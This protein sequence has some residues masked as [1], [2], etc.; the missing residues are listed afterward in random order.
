[1]GVKTTKKSK[2]CNIKTEM[3]FVKFKNSINRKV[4]KLVS[5]VISLLI[6]D[7]DIFVWYYH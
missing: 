3:L 7:S 5:Q 1:M 2:L 6:A 4:V